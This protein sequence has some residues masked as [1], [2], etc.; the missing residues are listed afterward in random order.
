[1]KYKIKK[2]NLISGCKKWNSIW[3]KEAWKNKRNVET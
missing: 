1:M 2:Y 3:T